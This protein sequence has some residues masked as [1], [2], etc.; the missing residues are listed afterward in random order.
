MVL[1]YYK[2]A[3]MHIG[4][5]KTLSAGIDCASQIAIHKTR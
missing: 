3:E 2:I 5:G 4:N 1:R